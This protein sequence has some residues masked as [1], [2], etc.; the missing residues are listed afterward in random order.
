MLIATPITDRDLW[1]AALRELPAAHVLQTWEWGAF[2]QRETGWSPERLLFSDPGGAAAA[3]ASILTRRAGP[4]RVMYVPKGPALEYGDP[5][6][7]DEVLDHLETLARRRRA[8]WLKIDPDVIAGTGV[9]GSAGAGPALPGTPII[10]DDPAGRGV[11]GILRAR[12]WR[13]SA[14]QVQFRNTITLDLTRDEEAILAGM[15]QST[16]RKVRAG[17]KQGVTVRVADSPADL[18][19][20][21]D[22]YTVTGARQGFL[23]RPSDYY[24]EAWARFFEAGLA[25][26]F[27][28]E[29]EGRAL[30]G[31]VLFHFGSKAW[32]FYGMSSNDERQRM[33]TYLLQWEAMRWAKAHGYATYDFWGAPDDFRDD[34]PMWGVYRFKEG[35]G[36]TVVRHIGAWDYV[37]Y[38]ALY[39][40]YERLM[41]RVLAIMRRAARPA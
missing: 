30:A 39:W 26:A 8:V 41:P 29:W 20:L 15:S 37:P 12:G 32:Y 5:A 14:S 28:A 16:R 25:V 24:R 3:A 19:T 13:F 7:L 11:V 4:L 31:L 36:G 22:L 23:I 18:Q 17:P 21:Y 9:P 2:K 38:P 35:F 33:P 6:P 40:A 10:A 34:D 1:N 27:L